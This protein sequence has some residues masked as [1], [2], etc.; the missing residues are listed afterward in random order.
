M[1]IQQAI[2]DCLAQGGGRARV[3][4][5]AY[6]LDAGLFIPREPVHPIPV[7]TPAV[8]L[9][10]DGINA[11]V[12]YTLLPEVDLLTIARSNVRVSGMLLQGAATA[13]PGRGVV[14]SDPVNGSVL[15]RVSLSDVYIAATGAESLYVPD[16]YPHL[17]NQPAYDRISVCCSYD[18]VTFDSNLGGDLVRLG[19]FNTTHRF[20]QCN[21]TNFKGHA[22]LLNGADTTS[23][24][25]CNLENGDNTKPWVEGVAAQATLLDHVY[26]EDHRPN[27]TSAVFTKRDK[28]STGWDERDCTFRRA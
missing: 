28:Q 4:A 5:G 13:G 8:E 26:A 17:V 12:I 23:L 27:G 21:F 6:R 3:P 19:R 15:S 22:L 9:C 18:R 25:D 14:V 1:D 24:R 16:G 11:T 10:G 7:L 2:N 20:T